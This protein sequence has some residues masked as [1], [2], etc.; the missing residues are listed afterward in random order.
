MTMPP[1][2]KTKTVAPPVQEQRTTGPVLPT[3]SE[4]D[5]HTVPE[6]R[7]LAKESGIAGYSKM[8]KADLI[9]ALTTQV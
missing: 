2:A 8:N 5:S 9:G 6:L 4:L 1:W 7:N 3:A